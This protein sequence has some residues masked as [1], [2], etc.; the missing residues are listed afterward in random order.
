MESPP[1]VS[2]VIPTVGRLAYLQEAVA[3]ALAQTWPRLEIVIGQNRLPSGE[4]DA[5]LDAW[6]QALAAR[7]PRVRHFNSDRRLGLSQ[8]FNASAR[9]ARGKY[10]AMLGDDDRLLPEFV[11]A[12][13]P[14]MEATDAA[15]GFSNHW[16]ID[17]E[18]IRL[19]AATAHFTR[20]YGRDTLAPGLQ[21]EPFA[22]VWRNSVPL[23]A[24]LI[25]STDVVRLG[26][27]EDI[28]TPDIEFFARLAAEGA[29]LVFVPQFLSE[30]RIHVGS[31][32]S[33]GLHYEALVDRL[34]GI[35]VP[36]EAQAHKRRFLERAI[37]GVAADCLRR[38]DTAGA[39][40]LIAHR[41]Y[42]RLVWSGGFGGEDFRIGIRA[43]LQRLLAVVPGSWGAVSPCGGRVMRCVDYS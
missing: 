15:V 29:R 30:Y 42:P 23:A 13:V 38:G 27:C 22:C 41:H 43:V 4:L 12:L 40:R 9:Q 35:A 14:A 5:D 34:E 31:E 11:A 21:V 37:A 2:I 25:R 17:A 24:A 39:R 6:A 28:N 36:P 8:N 32:T 18:G 20:Q 33:G 19:Q 26:F 16:F 3:S 7:D 1:L 10:L